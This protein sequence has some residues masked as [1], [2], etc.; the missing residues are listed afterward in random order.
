MI[1]GSFMTF[2]HRRW[3]RS[4][5]TGHHV[6]TFFLCFLGYGIFHLVRK[7]LSNVKSTITIEWR[8]LNVSSDPDIYAISEWE[9][10][11][12]C[13]NKGD[14][15]SFAG[16]LDTAFLLSYSLGVYIFGILGDRMDV[17][18]LLSGGLVVSSVALVLFA[19]VTEVQ[20]WYSREF[21]VSVWILFGFSHGTGFP[22]FLH[23]L[24]NWFSPVSRG[25]LMGIWGATKHLGN[26]ASSYLAAEFLPFGYEFPF[27]VNASFA[28][29]GG[30][31][32]WLGLVPS[33][34]HLQLNEVY[35]SN[36]AD[37]P[38]TPNFLQAVL[39][40]GVLSCTSAYVCLKLVDQSL[41]YWLPDYLSDKF[42]W[43][44]GQADLMA[45]YY[46]WG[47]LVGGILLGL[48][49]DL[50]R[51]RSPTVGGVTVA[52]VGLLAGYSALPSNQYLNEL[53]M[54]AV[55]FCVAGANTVLSGPMV[56]D[57]GRDANNAAV[58]TVSGIVD[59]TGSIIT[60]VGQ[61]LIATL[62]ETYDWAAVFYLLIAFTALSSL[63]LLPLIIR[64]IK[65][66]Y[67]SCR[68]SVE[69]S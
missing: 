61:T 14:C 54:G 63:F 55:G 1:F 36:E 25:T 51:C 67:Q 41:F 37:A 7:T 3:E 59:G 52:A 8:P 17:R 56:V 16:G 60:A 12:L 49:T 24:G 35:K 29:S 23:V 20:Q 27:L 45:N 13:K 65:K 48:T 58:A 26:I 44:N 31:V 43:S 50:L 32:I 33:P 28:L 30:V 15:D 5:W 68:L 47:G 18:F 19:F 21:L 11:Q 10:H 57:L 66:I 2:I 9:S 40:P 39:L 62:E 42:C 38:K 46:D 22:S 6:A 4:Q 69:Q 53:V 34:Q 64:D